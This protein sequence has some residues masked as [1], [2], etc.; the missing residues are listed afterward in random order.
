MRRVALVLA[1]LAAHAHAS[2]WTVPAEGGGEVDT[3]VQRVETGP[4]LPPAPEASGVLRAGA[5]LTHA[6]QLAGGG[7]AFGRSDLTR[8]V[9][10][11]TVS[12][13]NVTMLA[14]DRV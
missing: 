8:L 4:G 9:T 10:D 2:P 1:A 7:D 3:N 14:G 6:G 12:V 11:N 5:K 13:E